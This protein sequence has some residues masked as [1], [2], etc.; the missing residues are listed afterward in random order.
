MA[1]RRVLRNWHSGQ[2]ID[3]LVDLILDDIFAR[4]Q[5]E[6]PPEAKTRASTPQ[7]AISTQSERCLDAREIYFDLWQNILH[8]IV[9]VNT[10]YDTTTQTHTCRRKREAV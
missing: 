9:Y 8:F 5:K 1:C 6:P 2:N 10:L 4:M 7:A 3:D